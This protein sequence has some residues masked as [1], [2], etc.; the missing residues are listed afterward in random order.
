VRTV[1]D[2]LSATDSVVGA[3]FTNFKLASF[4]LASL[5]LASFDLASDSNIGRHVT[6]FDLKM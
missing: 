6:S 1:S 3:S 2:L 4:D 5:D